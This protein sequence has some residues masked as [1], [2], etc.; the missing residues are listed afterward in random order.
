MIPSSTAV[1]HITHY[2]SSG[3]GSGNA[4]ADSAGAS[5]DLNGSD[6]T[7]IAD[8]TGLSSGGNGSCVAAAA[9]IVAGGSAAD[10]RGG[11]LNARGLGKVSCC[12]CTEIGRSSKGLR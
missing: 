4:G 5:L 3:G 2:L 10:S 9:A 11:G 12:T 6:E 7:T 1:K 8:N